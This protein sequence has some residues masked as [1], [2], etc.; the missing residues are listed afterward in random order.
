MRA[1][2]GFP[3]G[4]VTVEQRRITAGLYFAGFFCIQAAFVARVVRAIGVNAAGEYQLLAVGRKQDTARFGGEAGNLARAGSIRV[5]D[6]DLGRTAPIRNESNL[7]RIGRPPGPFV[8]GSLR[9]DLARRSADQRDRVDL[10]GLGV[11]RQI[12]G[13]DGEGDRF[14]VGGKRWLLNPREL[15]QSLHIEGL[16]LGREA[17]GEQQ[18]NAAGADKRHMTRLCHR[19]WERASVRIDICAGLAQNSPIAGYR[20]VSP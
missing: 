8:I 6:P 10:L 12:D 14:A 7:L 19:V 11:L 9:G 15:E 20:K 16:L 2:L 4:P 13:L 18:E 5:H 17:G 3:F 1:P